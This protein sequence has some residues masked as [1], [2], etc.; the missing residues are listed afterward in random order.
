MLWCGASWV[1]RLRFWFI[2]AGSGGQVWYFS[3]DKKIP[4]YLIM[5]HYLA[6]SFKVC[7]MMDDRQ[8][9][10]FASKDAP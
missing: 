8:G 3:P 5:Y 2:L 9:E 10:R 4:V 7:Q 1:N 6:S